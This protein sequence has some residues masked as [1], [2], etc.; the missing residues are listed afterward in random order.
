MTRTPSGAVRR[1]AWVAVLVTAALAG[2]GKG[3]A[4][5][6]DSGHALPAVRVRTAT[7][8][9]RPFPITLNAT[10]TIVARPGSVATLSAPAPARITRVFASEGDLVRRGDPLVAFDRAAFQAAFDQAQ[11]V[12]LSARQEFARATRLAAQGILPTRD[13]EQARAAHAQAAAALVVASRS[14]ELATLRSPITGVVSKNS[15]VLDASVD[16]TQPLVQVVDPHALE[17]RILLA[18]GDAAQ[19]HRDAA[20]TLTTGSGEGTVVARGRVLAIAPT[21]DSLTGTVVVR[22]RVEAPSR[23]LRLGEVVGVRIEA[24]VQANALVVPVMALVPSSS[25]DGYQVFVVTAGDT[26]RARP[27]T[28][29]IRSAGFAMVTDGVSAGEVVVADGA[30]GVEDGSRILSSGGAPQVPAP[31]TGSAP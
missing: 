7:V 15:A 14:L 13:V 18:A 4:G 10:G 24:G 29:G 3:R 11:A 5:G 28:V 30:F 23:E 19:I 9:R 31:A 12:E 16:P 25:G 17:A 21:I 26:A 1:A 27:V 8:V 6:S 20:V 2:C 22:A